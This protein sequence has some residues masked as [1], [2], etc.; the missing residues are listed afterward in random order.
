[1]LGDVV[2]GSNWSMDHD[3][4][5]EVIVDAFVRTHAASWRSKVKGIIVIDSI[6]RLSCPANKLPMIKENPRFDL[7][8][9]SRKY[10]F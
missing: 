4:V 9:K 3:G 2:G 7:T 8:V 10:K 6:W 5:R 1:M